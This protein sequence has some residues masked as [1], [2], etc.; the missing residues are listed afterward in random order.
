M[1]VAVGVIPNSEG[2]GLET[3]GIAVEN[4]FVRV[5]P[6]FR[7][8]CET[9]WAV[10]DLIGPPLLAH[11]ASA[12]AIAAVEAMA[13]RSNRRINYRAIPTCVYCQ[14]EAASVG[15][16]ERRARAEGLN[17][18]MTKSP[19]LA[20]GKAVAMG[21]TDGFAKLVFDADTHAILGCHLVGHGASELINLTAL[22]IS[23]GL[24][25]EDV[26]HAIYAHPTRAELIG[27]TAREALRGL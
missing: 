12:E 25:I 5:G 7:T 26:A 16:T 9:V 2:L 27:D 23:A 24:K 8:A 15:W 13:G 3:L 22:A 14:P 1:L 10:G 19:F 20:N 6:D 4:G 18:G 17:V 11:A 21:L